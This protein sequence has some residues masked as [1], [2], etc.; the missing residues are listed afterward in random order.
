[1]HTFAQVAGLV[2]AIVCVGLTAGVWAA[3]VAL[4][5]AITL[6]SAAVESGSR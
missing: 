1:M 2:I 6:V 5:L 3:G 4:G